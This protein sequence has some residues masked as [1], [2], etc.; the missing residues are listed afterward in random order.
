MGLNS[1]ITVA[2][3]GLSPHEVRILQTICLLSKE[4]PRTYRLMVPG[5]SQAADFAIV[6]GDD[7][8]A[9]AAWQQFRSSHPMLHL[10]MV[11]RH[12]QLDGPGFEI[13]RPLLATRLLAM[14]DRIELSSE[15]P[16]LVPLSPV[17]SQATGTQLQA[18]AAPTPTDARLS[19]LIVDDS[20]LIRRQ[21]QMAL[22]PMVGRVDQAEDGLQAMALIAAN[23]YDIVFLDVVLPGADG[24]KICRMIK[25]DKRAKDTPVIMLT[26]KSSPFDRVKGKLAGCDTYLTKPVD[27]PTFEKV[28]RHY[29]SQA[30]SSRDLKKDAVSSPGIADRM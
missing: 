12:S 27:T 23:A 25:Q 22:E 13:G 26:G 8:Q 2:V 24:Y 4:R 29:L 7:P 14:F 19:A 16:A 1:P 20:L 15:Q 30:K 17:Q 10:V 11:G 3:F 6:D 21:M 9:M 28:L 18:P 5:E